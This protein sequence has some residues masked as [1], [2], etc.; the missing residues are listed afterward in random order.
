M[1]GWPSAKMFSKRAWYLVK[2]IAELKDEV[3]QLENQFDGLNGIPQ[4]SCF[5]IVDGTDSPVFEP[6]VADA[7]DPDL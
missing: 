1:V 6:V 7:T 2:R 5:I 4:T 3:I